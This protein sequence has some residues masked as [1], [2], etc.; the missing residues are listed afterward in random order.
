MI[1]KDIEIAQQAKLRPVQEIAAEIGVLDDE[2]I[3]YGRDVAKI[4]QKILKR[5][6]TTAGD[7]RYVAV[8][9]ITPTPFG[10]GKTTTTVGLTQGLGRLG[11]RAACAIRQPSLGPTFGIKGGAAGG[12][13]SQVLP[14][15]RFNLHLTGDTHAVAVAHNLI[16]AAVDARLYHEGR[17]SDAYFEK[18]GLA[19]I[20]M[21]PNQVSWRRV[22]DISDRGLRN[23][24]TGLGDAG[25]GPMRQSGFDIA[26]ASELMAIL[27]LS[28][29]LADMRRRVGRTVVAFDRSGKPVSCDDIGVGGAATVLL[30][31]ALAPN[32]LQTLEGQP[33]FVHSGPFANIAHGNSSIM[34]DLVGSRLGG[35]LITESGFGSE[36]G[37]EKFFDIKCR[38]SGLR[39][40]AVVMVAT[41]R[42][43][44]SHGGGPSLR[45]GVKPD[46]AYSTERLDLVQE[47]LANLRAH[48]AIAT[49]FG[50]PIVVAINVFPG[51]SAAEIELVRAAAIEAGAVDAVMST[52]FTDGGAGAEKLA[53][54]VVAACERPSETRLLYEVDMPL[55]EKIELLATT[56]Y[57]A[58]GV[59]F[60][61]QALDQIKRYTELGWNDMPICM[62]KTPLSLS[63]DPTRKNV[64]TDYMFPVREIRAGVGAGFLYPLSGDVRI[65]PG[66]PATPAFMNVDIDVETGMVRGLF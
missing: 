11:R 55:R 54:A 34:A 17:W 5:L 3:P 51:D 6:T 12:G 25:D 4:D 10:E 65:M 24:I 52:H 8:T 58:K 16:A 56:L 38:A 9:A 14:M 35:Y 41:I 7:F 23:I 27:A 15:E 26:V 63:H 48:I 57:G 60:A 45:A 30:R 39:P 28:T 21:D 66:L 22:I 32:L 31:D 36:M 50:A 62:A 18:R 33:A 37:L 59:E 47:G 46:A 29:D 64:P 1:P 2:L 20:N 44:K 61:S 43:L 42:A 13:Y 49:R 53:E 19:K 40:H